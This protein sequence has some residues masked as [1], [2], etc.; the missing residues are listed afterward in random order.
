MLSART[1]PAGGPV[2]DSLSVSPAPM[3]HARRVTLLVHGYNNTAPEALAS[4]GEFLAHTGLEASLA[5]GQL[6]EFLWPGDEDWGILRPLAYPFEIPVAREAA[7]RLY[8]FLAA[9]Q[10]AGGWPLEVRLVCHS[11]GNRLLLELLAAH[12]AAGSP[13]ALRFTVCCLM[14]AAVPVYMVEDGGELRAA[15]AAPGRTLVLFSQADAV[16]RWAFPLGQSAAGEGFFPTA[17]GRNGDPAAGLWSAREAMPG[18][19]HGDY[20][21]GAASAARVTEFLGGASARPLPASALGGHALPE[22][23]QAAARTIADRS[24]PARSLC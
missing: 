2:A 6:C 10:P 9:L 23:A 14:A 16:L 13:E 4:Y 7:Q 20:W 19:G 3:P 21:P 8:A 17:V 11:L 24:L 1:R 22:P 15:A 12:C 18:Y 5:A